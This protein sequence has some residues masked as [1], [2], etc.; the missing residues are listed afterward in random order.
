MRTVSGGGI[1]STDASALKKNTGIKKDTNT[2]A[3]EVQEDFN[4]SES[5]E[6]SIEQSSHFEHKKLQDWDSAPNAL[7][8]DMEKLNPPL[9]SKDSTFK[10]ALFELKAKRLIA[11]T[12]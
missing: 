9:V 8:F 5:L 4:N 1:V 11:S 10:V 3:R 2:G 6:P 7:S 12:P